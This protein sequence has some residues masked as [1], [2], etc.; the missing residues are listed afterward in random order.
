M[1]YLLLLAAMQ[2]LQ[3]GITAGDGP[4]CAAQPPLIDRH[5]G[6]SETWRI[7]NGSSG[8]CKCYEFFISNSW[9]A[10]TQRIL[11]FLGANMLCWNVL[12]KLN[13]SS[14]QWCRSPPILHYSWPLPGRASSPSMQPLLPASYL[15][16]AALSLPCWHCAREQ[17][18][19]G[20]GKWIHH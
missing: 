6:F 12:K 15:P 17:A 20:R 18:A 4:R 10:L 3:F 9:P 2:Y 16:L 19:M 11:D 13:L 7:E 5:N 14:L 1:H 8:D